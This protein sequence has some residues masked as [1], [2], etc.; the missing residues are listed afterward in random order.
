MVKS[1][2]VF[3]S[4]VFSV[5]ILGLSVRMSSGTGGLPCDGWTSGCGTGL[6][7]A[8]SACKRDWLTPNLTWSADRGENATEARN[9]PVSQ[10]DQC[11]HIIVWTGIWVPTTIQCGGFSAC[12]DCI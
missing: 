7:S 12:L 8:V 5:I 11:G 9:P 4:A 2:I 10:T 3:N 6:I 1:R